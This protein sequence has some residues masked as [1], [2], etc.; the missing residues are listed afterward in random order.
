MI[1]DGARNDCR[2][3]ADGIDYEVQLGEANPE[4]S[5]EPSLVVSDGSVFRVVQSRGC[6][7]GPKADV[8]DPPNAPT[9]P[10]RFF[11]GPLI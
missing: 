1:N 6:A 11:S 3:G 5:V 8:K 10:Q 9:L 4:P 7:I 2:R